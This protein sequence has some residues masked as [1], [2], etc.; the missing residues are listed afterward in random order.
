M[1]L[2]KIFG[3]FGEFE[4]FCARFKGNYLLSLEVLYTEHKGNVY[5]RSYPFLVKLSVGFE[6][7]FCSEE[8]QA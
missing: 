5:C 1:K 4:L 6:R 7:A 3:E 8:I 2:Y